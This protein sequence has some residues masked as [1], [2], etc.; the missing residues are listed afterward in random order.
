[1]D[2]VKGALLYASNGDVG[3]LSAY[4]V[5]HREKL[6]DVYLV[7]L[8]YLP[9]YIPAAQVTALVKRERIEINPVTEVNDLVGNVPTLKSITLD[10]FLQTRARNVLRT[11]G[12]LDSVFALYDGCASD[13]AWLEGVVEPLRRLRSLG[14]EKV[15]VDDLESLDEGALLGMTLD[16][17][18]D[19]TDLLIS[20]V[21]V[22]LAS[23]R[24][25]VGVFDRVA[26][27]ILKTTDRLDQVLRIV[28]HVVQADGLAV[29]PKRTIVA[30]ALAA[31]YACPDPQS[32][33]HSLKQLGIVLTRTAHSFTTS[34]YGQDD[35]PKVLRTEPSHLLDTDSI[36]FPSMGNIDLFSRLTSVRHMLGPGVSLY[37]LYTLRHAD[38]VVQRDHL[39]RRLD[40]TADVSSLRAELVG[41]DLLPQIDRA[42]I[43]GL[44]LRA[45]L[46]RGDLD[47]ARKLYVATSTRPI[48]AAEVES[49][50]LDAFGDVIK[51]AGSLTKD[52]DK[53]VRCA[54]LLSVI[55]PKH[56]GERVKRLQ[57]LVDA[58]LELAGFRGADALTPSAF[59]EAPDGD[60]VLALIG[61][62]VQERGAYRKHVRLLGLYQNVCVALET[63]PN[64]P[65]F[66]ELVV[67]AALSYDNLPFALELID[68][69]EQR[70]Q[71]G[72]DDT[73]GAEVVED[74]TWRL[75]YQVCRYPAE[76]S[77]MDG[78][79]IELLSRA[80]SRCPASEMARLLDLHRQLEKSAREVALPSHP[81]A[82][83]L[84]RRMTSDVSGGG[85]AST[86]YARQSNITDAPKSLLEAARSATRAA[87]QALPVGTVVDLYRTFR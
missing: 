63:L 29:G 74:G 85:D 67:N 86:E 12:D 36:T 25:D 50:V 18:S 11:T 2:A 71:G 41:G 72:G 32:Q 53:L 57:L 79:K 70:H 3:R 48:P 66:N 9:E 45:L 62:V 30:T 52:K 80:L 10:E 23:Y 16:K 6:Q 43:E 31:S 61:R 58:L 34:V 83:P 26:Q 55:H 24:R 8:L 44:V 81:R 75:I 13:R 14:N 19:D 82:P 28:T 20:D 73:G 76:S 51:T 7:V 84:L 59:L 38:E 17:A 68:A 33:A 40:D 49:S 46:K 77:A 60:A 47:A 78:Q 37:T 21:L 22:P 54:D 65:A 39:A 69:E 35:N 42:Q 56:A 27:Y 15:T 4:E 1:M 87:R 5:E 64:E